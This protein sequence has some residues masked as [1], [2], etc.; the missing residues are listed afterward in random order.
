ME[1][2]V[3]ALAQ[4]AAS[5]AARGQWQDAEQLWRQVRA[6]DPQHPRALYSLGLHALRRGDLAEA[7]ALLQQARARAPH[8]PN[9]LLALA[10]VQRESG[11]RVAELQSIDAALA[12]DP[13]FLPGLL[14]KGL[15]LEQHGHAR[16]AAA[17]Y[18]NALRIAPPESHWPAPLRNQLE[19]ARYRA[20]QQA[21]AMAALFADRIG[22]PLQALSPY[23][24]ER[25]REAASI[26]GG[27]SR[28]YP[29]ACSQLQ[30][31]RLP[32]VPFFERERFDWVEALEVRTAAITAELHAALHGDH[33]GFR[34][35]VAYRP[36]DPVNQWQELN[37]SHR[38]SSYSLWRDGVPNAEHLAR[39]PR[40]AQALHE[41][42]MADIGGLCPN[43][44]FSAL[45][46]HT[47][48]PPHHGETNARVVVHLPL[49]VPERCRYRV[50][51][52]Q[53]QWRVGEV[54]VFD[55]SIEHE[56][57]ND[58]DE[59]RVVLIFDVWNPLLSHGERELVRTLFAARR[60]FMEAGA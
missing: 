17:T 50:G 19:H 35:Y 48:I 22:A 15:H 57:R 49:V 28:P 40:T 59:L 38:W 34:P 55:D 2:S 53:R 13:Y 25:W 6:A 1:A 4:A 44:M 23:E 8:D 47:H 42:D 56:A 12:T 32:A 45:A 21:E 51:F 58:S 29:S 18:A 54:L 39:C 20:Q 9:V 7:L 24:A 52:E 5:A 26:L 16:L 43:A 37:H 11:D 10:N 46:P 60:E 41:V 36:G 14:A 31:P 3:E 27:L 33:A 30:I